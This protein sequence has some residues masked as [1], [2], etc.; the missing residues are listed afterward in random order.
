MGNCEHRYA[1]AVYNAEDITF[2]EST[3]ENEI[4]VDDKGKRVAAKKIVCRDCGQTLPS[5]FPALGCG[6]AV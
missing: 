4:A 3:K 6:G 1:E 2:N 5:D